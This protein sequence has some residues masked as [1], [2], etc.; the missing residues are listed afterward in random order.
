MSKKKLFITFCVSVHFAADEG[1]KAH[2]ETANVLL[3]HGADINIR[4]KE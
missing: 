4:A 3:Q 1:D 2:V